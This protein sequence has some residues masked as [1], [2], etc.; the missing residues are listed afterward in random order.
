M[1][2][3]VGVTKTIVD[4]MKKYSPQ[5]EG[6]E[7]E[8]KSPTDGQPMIET[9]RAFES[10]DGKLRVYKIT[11]GRRMNEEE[12][13]AL[14]EKGE[15]GPFEDC[16]SPK[17]GKNYTAILRLEKDEEKDALKVRIILPNN[18]EDSG[19][20]D[21]IWKDDKTGAELCAGAMEY[22][23]RKPNGGEQPERLFRMGRTI[24]Q[25][26][27]PREQVV[28]LVTEGKT[29]P[30]PDFIS[31]RG[32]KFTAIL[33]RHGAKIGWEFP[34]REKK[35]PRES[36]AGGKSKAPRKSTAKAVDL[37]EAK[38]IGHAAVHDGE[39]L[40]TPEAFVVRKGDPA[41]GRVVFKMAKSICGREMTAEDARK[42]V[43][44][45]RTDLIENFVSKRGSAF[46]AYLVLSDDKKKANF[47]FP[48][49]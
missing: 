1:Q 22:V 16:R 27:V 29:D 48:P 44:E 37:S 45:G 11:A 23:L 49:R 8:W 4:R 10:R 7:L 30:I 21:V 46:S 31:K 32:R 39:L 26:E 13:R 5:E 19:P 14:V 25:R 38:A 12:A 18:Q 34:P 2:E 35:E 41:E 42:L 36:G 9:H 6:R 43:D 20:L 28:K 33:V 15:I 24:C 17:T 47:E 40:E 3:I